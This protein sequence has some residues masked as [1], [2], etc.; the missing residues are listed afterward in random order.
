MSSFVQSAEP[1][2]DATPLTTTTNITGAP[3]DAETSRS[4]VPEVA[5]TPRSELGVF[6]PNFDSRSEIS[7][8][9]NE[10]IPSLSPRT[11]PASPIARDIEVPVLAL[12]GVLALST[13]PKVAAEGAL[14]IASEATSEAS[15]EPVPP[16]SP[17]HDFTPASTPTRQDST[18]QSPKLAQFNLAPTRIVCGV[19]VKFMPSI[20]H[21]LYFRALRQLLVQLYQPKKPL[22]LNCRSLF[23]RFL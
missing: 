9:S 5:T 3:F 7:A 1:D 20:T 21:T 6:T 15:I 23:L 19:T 18:S 13:D 4:D 12:G 10:P 16:S 17:V 22:P 2:G 11:D 8:A 14:D